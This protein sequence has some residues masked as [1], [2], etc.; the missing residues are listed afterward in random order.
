MEAITVMQLIDVIGNLRV[1]LFDADSGILLADGHKA[2]NKIKVFHGHLV[3]YIDFKPGRVRVR[4][5]KEVS[6]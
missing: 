6:R 2:S 4:I 3:D 5:Y 1:Q